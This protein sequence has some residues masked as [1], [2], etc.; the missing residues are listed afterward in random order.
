MWGNGF[1]GFIA[2]DRSYTMSL[3]NLPVSEL[4]NLLMEE[5]KKLTTA[6]R[7]GYVNSKKEEI[8]N[9]IEEIIKVLEEEKK[10]NDPMNRL[11]GS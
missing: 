8:R 5:T 2:P 11:T 7:E 3:A 1:C 10:K 4:Q 9:K 6:L